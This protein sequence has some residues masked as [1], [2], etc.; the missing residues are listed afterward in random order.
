MESELNNKA[1]VLGNYNNIPTEISTQALI[2]TM[3]NGLNVTKTADKMIWADG[4]LTYT[5]IVSNDTAET[6]TSPVI[7]DTL[8]ISLVSFV[9]N[10]VTIDNKIA[11]D[12][13]YNYN[14]ATGV[15]TINLPDIEPSLK[16]EVTFQ[17]TKKI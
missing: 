7:T 11:E 14:E 12:S 8:D 13:Q 16:K 10:S 3:I 17:V 5:L 9:N 4:T 15:L 6:Y 2:V 1:T